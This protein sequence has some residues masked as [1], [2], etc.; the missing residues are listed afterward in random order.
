MGDGDAEFWRNF[1]HLMFHCRWWQ[2]DAG[3]LENPLKVSPLWCSG[4]SKSRNSFITTVYA[5][6][7]ALNVYAT[8]KTRLTGACPFWRWKIIDAN[9]KVMRQHIMWAQRKAQGKRFVFTPLINH[10]SVLCISWIKPE[11]H[12]Q[13]P[14]KA[15]CTYCTPGELLFKQ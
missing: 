4:A 9:D 5:Q 7:W 1:K 10:R 2:C 12:L 8:I 14:L 6:N 15:R 3:M 11:C 13:F